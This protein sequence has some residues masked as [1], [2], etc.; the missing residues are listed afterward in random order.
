MDSNIAGNIF[1]FAG[2][3][4]EAALVLYVVWSRQ[5]KGQGGVPLYLTALLCAQ[6][7]RAYV[8]QQLG[9]TSREYFYV[10]WTTDPL[11]VISAFLVVCFFFQRACQHEEKMWRSIRMLLWFVFVL[12]VGIS[13]LTF[14]RNYGHLFTDFIYEFN[15]NLYFTCLVLNT[16]LYVL[17]QQIESVDDRLGLLVCG[18]GIQFAWPDGSVGSA[19]SHRRWALRPNIN[20]RHHASLLFWNAFSV[21]VRDRPR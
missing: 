8:L 1:Q 20:N 21:G 14:Y 16:L 12:V 11:V 13:G 15:Q 17:L 4:I 6:L 3:F 19:S 10:Y 9:P 7:T 5:W 18:V 2:I